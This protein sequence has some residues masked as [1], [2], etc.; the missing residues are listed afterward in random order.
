MGPEKNENRKKVFTLHKYSINNC[1]TINLLREELRQLFTTLHNTSQHFTS[2]IND[3]LL[4]AIYILQLFDKKR[5][6]RTTYCLKLK[7]VF[8]VKT[9]EEM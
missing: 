6:K 4:K 5:N 1:I 2:R 8:M 3:I 9:R 7:L